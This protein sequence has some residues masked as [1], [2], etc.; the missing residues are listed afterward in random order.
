MLQTRPVERGNVAPAD[1]LARRRYC[2]E[3]RDA[4]RDVSERVGAG[5]FD[6]RRLQERQIPALARHDIEGSMKAV[7]MGLGYRDNFHRVHVPGTGLI[8]PLAESPGN[9]Y[10]GFDPATTECP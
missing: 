4:L 5:F 3:M 8:L 10:L 6:R 2:D 1:D 9:N 7:D